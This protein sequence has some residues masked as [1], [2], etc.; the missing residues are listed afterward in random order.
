MRWIAIASLALALAACNAQREESPK[1]EAPAQGPGA[2]ASQTP[3]ATTPEAAAPEAPPLEPQTP[4][5]PQK[6][7]KW[8]LSEFD[9]GD[10][11]DTVAE[12]LHYTDGF[13]CYQHKLFERC[14][15][16]K[17]KIDGEEL[18]AQFSFVDGKL[19]R[20][21][22]LTPDLDAT[23]ADAHL[24][25]VWK[26]LAAWVT[27]FKGEAPEQTP[28]PQRGALAPKQE[29]VTHRWRLPDQEI[30]ILVGGAPDEGKWF[31]AARFVDP[32]WSKQDPPPARVEPLSIPKKGA[33]L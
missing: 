8:R 31:T 5:A 6:D 28:F 14:A 2:Q 23:Q 17:T 27:R 18:L 7:E 30:R 22:V 33:H 19:W 20:I 4:S 16:V 25:R 32:A 21:D 24:E 1:S 29:V 9:W 13:L 12:T 10:S 15:F 3:P 26:L 11:P